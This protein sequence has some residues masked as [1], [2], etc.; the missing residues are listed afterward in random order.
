MPPKS[1]SSSAF[2]EPQAPSSAS[3]TFF[4]KKSDKMFG[5]GGEEVT[6]LE[7]ENIDK[8]FSG[9]SIDLI[10]KPLGSEVL[11]VSDEWFAEAENLINPKAPIRRPGVFTHAGAWYDGWETRRHNPEEFDWAVI[12]LGV[13]SG[14]VKGVEIDTA[15]FDGNHAPEIAVQGFFAG[16]NEDADELV[17]DPE[18][19]GWETI[20]SKQECGP[21]QRHGWLLAKETEKAYTHVRLQMFPDGGIARF[22]LFGSVVPVFPASVDEAFDLA[23][24]VNGGVALS[25][26]DQ[27][28][29]TKDNL[30]LPGRGVDMG[31]GWETKR[32]R[33]E[34][35]DWTIV[36]LGTPA[37]IE[38]VVVDTAHFRGNFPK[39]V[40]IFAGDFQQDPG[41]E[42]PGWVEILEPIG[43]GPDQEHEYDEEVLKDVKVK[44]YSHVKL[45]I[46][47][48]GGVKRL[49]VFGKRR[50]W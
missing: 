15:F 18:F 24:A 7:V 45:V 4:E 30:L 33:G 16:S 48:D 27:H 43:T 28:F 1:H 44:A 17:K 35:I 36:R 49:R 8:T 14:K 25:C 10:S 6:K 20:L 22:R 23:A 42:D 13:A 9:K 47:P 12:K 11:A 46:I 37:E 39:Q 38:R 2:T 26:S 3:G 32:T 40:Q 31:D 5:F 50:A 29:G 34:H 19:G 21:S 41:H